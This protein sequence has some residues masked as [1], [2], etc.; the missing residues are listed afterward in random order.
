VDALVIHD[1]EQSSETVP[2]AN[3]RGLTI[4][5]HYEELA[6]GGFKALQELRASGAISAFGAGVNADEGV[7]LTLMGTPFGAATMREFNQ[8]YCRRLADLS[9]ED[10][11]NFFLMANIYSLLD[12]TAH[13]DGLLD[14]CAER[15]IGVVRRCYLDSPSTA[16]T[17]SVQPAQFSW[18][19]TRVSLVWLAR[20][21]R[22]WQVIG[23]PFASGI[24]AGD[25]TEGTYVY[26]AAPPEVSYY[27]FGADWSKFR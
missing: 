20:G 27:A 4:E 5:Q 17:H 26:G 8:Q 10:P 19:L 18:L 23:G 21:K 15:G 13:A 14:L 16:A 22:A 7:D 12:F 2:G 1:M 25:P 11:I 3:P 9:T 6:G 24:L